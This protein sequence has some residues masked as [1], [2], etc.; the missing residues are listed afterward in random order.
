ML[1]RADAVVCTSQPYA[2]A[3]ITLR[4]FK[5]KITVIPLGVPTT[6]E[7]PS[8][9][10]GREALQGALRQ[11]VGER[12]LVLCVGRLV[13][14]KGYATLIEAA[15]QLQS[16]AAIVV[17]GG[18]PLEAELKAQVTRQGVGGR[19]MFTGR[20][21]DAT[22]AALQHL[23]T[24]YCMPSVERSEAFGVALIEA[25]SKGLPLLA[26]EIPG[27]GVPWVN[28][29]RESGLNVR[30]GDAGGLAEALDQLLGDAHLRQQLSKGGRSR[31][32]AFFTEQRMV[33]KTLSLY[34]SLLDGG[35]RS[36]GMSR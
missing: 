22:L 27:S 16:D 35:S 24:V 5:D 33:E 20:V 8:A 19:V 12:P 9:L 31:Y 30:P 25:M 13:P 18:G 14:Y 17:V 28:K 6:E 3:S 4:P 21:D 1:Q 15:C 36:S 29:H 34:E 10:L 32:L 2:D 26:T 7:A 11:H 23:A